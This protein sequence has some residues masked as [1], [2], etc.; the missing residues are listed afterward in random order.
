MSPPGC[1]SKQTRQVRQSSHTNKEE[2]KWQHG[3]FLHQTAILKKKLFASFYLGN[4]QFY[5]E[6]AELGIPKIF[7]PESTA[8]IR[9]HSVV[10]VEA[11]TTKTALQRTVVFFIVNIYFSYLLLSAPPFCLPVS[12]QKLCRAVNLHSANQNKENMHFKASKSDKSV[13]IL[14]N[15]FCLCLTIIHFCL[16]HC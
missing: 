11:C 15:G 10:R 2:G 5:C 4:G 16:K 12:H 13:F 7:F 14:F 8:F 3:H 9:E 1:A 6:K